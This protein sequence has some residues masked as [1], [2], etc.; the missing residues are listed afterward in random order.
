MLANKMKVGDIV[1]LGN[2]VEPAV[3]LEVEVDGA[4]TA[5]RLRQEGKRRGV[6]VAM[7]ATA[8]VRRL[9]R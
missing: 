7:P 2:D 3:V 9:R 8:N 6:W 1:D 5:L 4:M